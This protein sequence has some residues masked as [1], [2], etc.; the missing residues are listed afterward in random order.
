MSA[1]MAAALSACAST[2]SSAA[3]SSEA[4]AASTEAAET[5][6]AAAEEG[7]TYKIGIVQ[8]VQHPALDAA[9]KG[10]E[11]EVKAKLG[12]VEF[13]EQNASGD[14]ATASQIANSFVTEGSQKVLT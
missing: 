13:D 10:F 2:G 1:T 3:A 12:N 14:S 11:D 8:L 4:P 9:T 7:K 5:S 6:A